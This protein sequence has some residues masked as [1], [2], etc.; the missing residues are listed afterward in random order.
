MKQ[1]W[2]IIYHYFTFFWNNFCRNKYE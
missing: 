2:K 1:Y